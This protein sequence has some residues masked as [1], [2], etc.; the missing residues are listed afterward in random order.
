MSKCSNQSNPNT[1]FSNQDFKKKKFRLI[2]N[3]SY[4]YLSAIFIFLKNSKRVIIE[5][6]FQCNDYTLDMDN[7][8]L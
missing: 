2:P 6:D 4:S 3:F 8:D 7:N 1:E 5:Y